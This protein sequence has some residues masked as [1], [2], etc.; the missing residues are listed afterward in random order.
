MPRWSADGKWV[1]YQY[2]PR[3]IWRIRVSGGKPEPVAGV[4]GASAAESPDGQ[5]LYYSGSPNAEPTSLR[6]IPVGGGAAAEVLPKVAGRNW[7]V[8]DTGIW[9]LT[10]SSAEGS[11]LQFYDF[12]SKAERTVFHTARPVFVGLTVSPDQRRILFTQIDAPTNRNLMLVENL[13]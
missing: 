5:W 11:L 10:P 1:Y 6:R 13:R 4:I 12:A 9:F 2:T 7:V 8:V 3:Q